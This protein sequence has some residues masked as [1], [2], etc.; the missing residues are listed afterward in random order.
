VPLPL[1][2]AVLALAATTS[3]T[4]PD[5]LRSLVDAERNFSRMSVEQGMRDAFLANM[6]DDGI[7]F[8]PLPVNARQV[9][10][11]RPKSS[12]TLIWEP[13]FA[14]IAAAGDLGYTTGP[15]ELRFPPEADRPTLY[16]HFHTVWRRTEGGPWKAAVDIGGSHQKLEPGVGSGDFAPGPAHG[17]VPKSDRSHSAQ[18]EILAAEQRF[19]REAERRGFA[20]AFARVSARDVRLGRE[21]QAPS[22]G[23]EAAHAALS[24][25]AGKVRWTPTGS[26]ASRSGDLGYAYGVRERF[27]E[28]GAPSDTTVYLDVWRREGKSWRLAL[29]VDNPVET[30]RAP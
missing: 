26:G 27:G 20:E 8:Q 18:S 9:W 16:G 4:G 30:R 1:F 21:G 28:A 13:A 15:W 10:G 12:A 25:D 11:P 29:M 5:A 3:T 24:G 14:E 7:V 19:S 17:N 6:A 23:L 2:P 22:V